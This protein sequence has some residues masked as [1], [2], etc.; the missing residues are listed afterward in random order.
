MLI[1]ATNR[2]NAIDAALRRP[3]RLDREIAVGPPNEKGRE[4]IL[5]LHLRSMPLE[6]EVSIE[7][8]AKACVGYVGADLAALAREAAL[9]ALKRHFEST[10]GGERGIK[11]EDF[12]AAMRQVGGSAGRGAVVNV[13]K[14]S[15]EDIGGLGDVKLKLIQAVEWPLLHADAFERL[16]I[17][18]ARGILLYGP[19]GCSKTSLVKAIT[20]PNPNT[21]PT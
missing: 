20:N 2:P 14:T 3:G 18:A 16:G 12:E 11:E 7:A 13:A 15:W 8:L 21:N 6:K 17:R 5:R 19:P 1:G 10:G 9:S 4:A